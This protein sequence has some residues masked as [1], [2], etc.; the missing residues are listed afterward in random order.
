MAEDFVNPFETAQSKNTDFVDPFAAEKTKTET[1]EPKKG[2]KDRLSTVLGETSIG[3]V[4]GAFSPEIT[5]GLGMAA[6]AFPVTAPAA[7]FLLGAGSAMR[8]ARPA[9][10]LGGAIAGGSGEIGAQIA[11]AAGQPEKVQEIVRFAAGAVTPEFGNLIKYAG[12]KLLNTVGLASKS[13]LSTLVNAISNDLGLDVKQLSPSQKKYIE[14][15]AN[16]IRGGATPEASKTVYSALESGA[17]NIVQRYNNQAFMLEREA[18]DISKASGD[19]VSRMMSQFESGAESMRQSAT[20]RA[21]NILANAQKR[22]DEIRAGKSGPMAGIDAQDV[23][24]QGRRAADEILQDANT[25]I[26]RLRQIAE[27]A[28]TTGA[29]RAEAAKETLAGVGQAQ[30]PTETGEAI[31]GKVTP[32]L[33]ELKATRAANAEANK[34]EA[35]NFAKLKEQQ[36]VMPK[37]TAAF[38]E[39]MQMLDQDIKTATL[40]AIK[41]PL[42]R[43]RQALDPVKEVEGVVVGQ[44]VTF[45]GLEQIRRFLRD[46]SYGIPAEGYDAI[47]QQMAGR[48]ADAVE[49]IQQEFSPSIKKFLEQY[50]IDSQPLNNF[51]TKLGQAIVGKEDFDLGRFVTDPASIGNQIFKTETG[52]KQLV[53]LLGGDTAQA[54]K[55]ARGY[56][57]DQLGNATSKDINTFVTR[58]ARD[59]IDQFPA[60]K[61]QLVAAADKMAQA[62]RV[63]AKRQTLSDT[64]RTEAQGLPIKAQTAATR[65]EQDV[66]KQIANIEKQR[67]TA[68]TKELT[69]G[70]R[71]AAKITGGAETDI[72]QSAKAVQRQAGKVESQAEKEAAAKLT[73]GQK[74]SAEGQKIK[75]QILGKTFPVERVKDIILSG[76][77]ALWSEV[78]PIIAADPTAKRAFA[79]AVR[80]VIADKALSSPKGAVDAFSMRVRPA[81]EQTGLMTTSELNSLE[82][83]IQKINQTVEGPRKTTLIQRAISNALIGEA[84]RGINAVVNPMDILF[85]RKK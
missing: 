69:A 9:A 34:G 18:Q 26:T 80:S 33:D 3:G 46:R 52:V 58:T 15:V 64:L 74:L 10:A 49:K 85:G 43:I 82:Q 17:E 22:A 83:Q 27:K 72:S 77:K 29:G 32:I 6:G 57:M 11:E 60:L 19:K 45:E 44:P 78:G 84:A 23:L 51:K 79:D 61:S 48:L 35:F 5:T 42:Q 1:K 8:A 66:A 21:N 2:F 55:L 47:N 13:D 53:D 20:E 76:D 54:E 62:E 81:I 24:A 40:D 25:R 4:L 14:K 36:G 30:R 56:V 7:P 71:E 50:R 37:D 65:T 12:G 68:A 67:E 75:D 28:R 63:G 59:W 16:D 73:E 39:T 41:S 70:E 31:R 38:N